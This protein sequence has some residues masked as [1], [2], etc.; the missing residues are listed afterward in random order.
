MD[1][2]RYLFE[3]CFGKKIP[4]SVAT[5]PE[6]IEDVPHLVIGDVDADHVQHVLNLLQGETVLT[7]Q[8]LEIFGC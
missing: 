3:P 7:R 6:V 2:L 1:V 4:F 5:L 8:Y